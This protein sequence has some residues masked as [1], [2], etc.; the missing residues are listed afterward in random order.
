MTSI[1]AF[2]QI[3]YRP[4][5]LKNTTYY[6]KSEGMWPATCH[7]YHSYEKDTLINGRQYAK[8]NSFGSATSISVFC[9]GANSFNSS[10]TN[11]YIRNDSA[12]KKVYLYNTPND[13]LLYDFN[14]TVGD[15]L[16]TAYANQGTL[17]LMSIDSILIG[18]HWHRRHNYAPAG[19]PLALNPIIEGIGG[20][21]GFFGPLKHFEHNGIL[22]CYSENEMIK[23][24]Q[25]NFGQ[26][27]NCNWATNENIYSKTAIKYSFNNN[28][29]N[30]QHFNG[31]LF[32]YSTNGELVFETKVNSAFLKNFDYLPAAIYILKLQS[33]GEQQVDKILVH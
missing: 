26:S 31:S 13:T 22:K 9:D 19:L 33:K 11:R 4:I 32:L 10:T 25:S 21:R 15:T 5:P 18:S 14:L 8:M 6:Y 23:Y 28:S 1:T 3:T 16:K 2:A 20:E 30:I 17:I 24:P 7:S 27:G 12:Q 29:L